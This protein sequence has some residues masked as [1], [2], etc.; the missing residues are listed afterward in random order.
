MRLGPSKYL[1]PQPASAADGDR[2]MGFANTVFG[3]SQ[4]EGSQVSCGLILC[5]CGSSILSVPRECVGALF[6]YKSCL[7]TKDEWAALHSAFH[8]PFALLVLW[9]YREA[10]GSALVST[11][12]FLSAALPPCLGREL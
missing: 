2:R 11:V 12:P 1:F 4:Q 5:K 3:V 8:F 7:Y 6:G 10:K 9:L